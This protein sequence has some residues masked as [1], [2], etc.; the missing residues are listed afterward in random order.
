ML[1]CDM[2]SKAYWAH[3]VSIEK[4]FIQTLSYVSLSDENYSTYSEAYSKLILQIGSEVDIVL[5]LYCQQ[6][7]DA[8]NGSRIVDYKDLINEREPGFCTQVVEVRPAN[9]TVQPWINWDVSGENT[10]PYW[11]TAYNKIKHNRTDVGTIDSET[12]E[13]Y[14]FANLKNV[15]LALA[16]LYQILTYI[17]YNIATE[18]EQEVVTPLP[19]SRLFE[20]KGDLWEDVNFYGDFAF[21]FDDGELKMEFSDVYY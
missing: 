17:Y 5:K 6:L 21:Y 18:E 7:D 1:T 8:F 19:G 11:W 10:S 13:Y 14:K 15:L 9:T 2:F 12:K 16:G 4:E 20:L 3:Y